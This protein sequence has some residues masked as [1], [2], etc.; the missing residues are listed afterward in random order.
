MALKYANAVYP[1][2][3][4]FARYVCLLGSSSSVKKLEIKEES[5]RGLHPFQRTAS[6]AFTTTADI[7]PASAL[8]SFKDLVTYLDQHKPSDQYTYDSKTPIVQGYPV[9]VYSEIIRFVRMILILEAN[10]ST[11]LID[12]YV[13]SKVDNSMADDPVV[14]DNFKEYIKSCWSGADSNKKEAL[15]LWLRFIENSLDKDLKGKHEQQWII[16]TLLI[17]VAI[18]DLVLLTTAAQ[19]LLE[20]ISFGPASISTSLKDRLE[21]FKSF[22]LSEKQDARDVMSHIFGIV[23][24]DQ[25]ISTQQVENILGEYC[26]LLDKPLSSHGGGI[27]VDRA[28]GAILAIGFLL[29]RCIYRKRQLQVELIRRCIQ[30][31]ANQ[32]E[33]APGVTFTLLASAACRALAEIGRIEPLPLLENDK[34]KRKE[35]DT[36]DNME[37]DGEGST[38]TSRKVIE[39]L[40]KIVKSSGKDP[41]VQ[42]QAILAL[43]QL[44]IPYSSKS[45]NVTTVIDTLFASADTKQ[46]ELFFAGGEAW[47][48]VAFGWKSQAIQ[49]HKDISNVAFPDQSDMQKEE[50]FQSVI[51]KIART[52]VTSD[53]SWYRKASCIWLLSILKFGK[54]EQLIQ[55]I[56]CH[57]PMSFSF[58]DISIY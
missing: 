11:I 48:M 30:C 57:Q 43:G 9:E 37:V 45:D 35:E 54:D 34:R 39:Q 52:Y 13:E 28:H 4:V 36:A 26:D 24:S 27:D 31:L 22:T 42:E 2:S 20:I 15:E 55:V 33:G 56:S 7:V 23:A 1:F 49:K 58:I 51:E 3:S 46:I 8:P 29:G 44:S 32:L 21:F 5:A 16:S 38:L 40:S 6:G 18:V 17:K 10:P 53:R 14:M 50:A 19:S 41:K 47:S 25:S 12:Q